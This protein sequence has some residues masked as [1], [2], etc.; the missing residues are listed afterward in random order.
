MSKFF[1]E[2]IFIL[3]EDGRLFRRLVWETYELVTHQFH[4]IGKVFLKLFNFQPK[5]LDA[6]FYRE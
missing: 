5:Y 6:F 2:L 4:K 3:Y 1:L